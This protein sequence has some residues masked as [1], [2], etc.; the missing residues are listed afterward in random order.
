MLSLEELG[1]KLTEAGRLKLRPLCV[2]GTDE[3]PEGAV[4]S[5]MVDRC[6]AKATYIS[7]FFEETPPLYIEARSRTML[8]WRTGLGWGFRNRI[9]N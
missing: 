7:A 1:K 6:I 4:P 5:Y 2:Y 8:H 9:P 3:I